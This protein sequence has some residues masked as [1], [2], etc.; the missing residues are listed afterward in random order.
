MELMLFRD[1]RPGVIVKVPGEGPEGELV[2]LLGGETE[3]VPLNKRLTL[4]RR[5][6]GEALRLAIRYAVHRLGRE[7]EPVAGDCAVVAVVPDGS[8]GDVKAHDVP[9]IEC[10]V[11]AVV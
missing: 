1:G 3:M 9:G 5:A 11:R 2:E 8:L 6:D 7:P 10:Y 4:V